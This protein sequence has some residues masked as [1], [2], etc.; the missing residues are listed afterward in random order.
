LKASRLDICREVKQI[1]FPFPQLET[2]HGED[3]KKK[4]K[5]KLKMTGCIWFGPGPQK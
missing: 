1:V 4:T 2:M 5:Q 3:G